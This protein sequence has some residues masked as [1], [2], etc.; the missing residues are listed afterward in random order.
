MSLPDGD[1]KTAEVLH[2]EESDKTW[3][4]LLTLFACES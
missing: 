2:L 1:L 4:D 3:S